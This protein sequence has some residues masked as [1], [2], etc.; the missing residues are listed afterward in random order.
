MF[1]ANLVPGQGF[2]SFTVHRKTDGV[3]ITG[4]AVPGTYEPTEDSFFGQLVNA[5][6]K[7]KEQWKQNGHPITH[8][9]IEYGAQQKAKAT[10]LLVLQ[11]GREFYV[12]GAN[13]PGDLN[14]L[15]MY[16]VEERTDVKKRTD[17]E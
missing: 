12:Q 2:Q 15:M 1:T 10:D 11:D 7:E 8:T 13:N 4:R 5:S 17:G 16:Y 3:T 9:I 14:V 6:Q